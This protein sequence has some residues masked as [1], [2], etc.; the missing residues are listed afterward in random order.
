[1]G[2]QL[3]SLQAELTG[4]TNRVA[5]AKTPQEIAMLSRQY[6]ERVQHLNDRIAALTPKTPPAS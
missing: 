1:M 2:T 6:S 3:E 4:I 5:N